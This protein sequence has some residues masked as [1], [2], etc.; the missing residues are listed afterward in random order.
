MIL[1][2]LVFLLILSV[3][4]LIHELGHFLVAKK[5]NIKVEEFG[6]GLP[7]RLFGIK[8]GETIYSLN[9]LPIGGFVKLY[10]EDE[11]GG[12]SVKIRKPKSE[13]RNA[14]IERAFFARSV[15][16]RAAVVVAGV[17]MNTLLAILIFYI[18][19]AVAGFQAQ[20]PL[21]KEHTFY[22]ANQTIKTDILISRVQKDSPADKINIPQYAQITALNTVVPVTMEEF[23]SLIKKSQGK[24]LSIT[25]IDPKTHKT[26]TKSVT[27]RVNP[28]KGQGALGVSLFGASTVT[29]RYETPVQKAFS[30]IG[31]PINLL[32]YN[33][34]LIGSLIKSSI[35]EHDATALSQGVA[36]PVGIYSLVGTIVQIPNIKERVLELLN[37]AGILSVS[38]AFFNVLPIPALD[39]GRLFFILIEGVTRKKINPK[40]EVLAHSIGMAVLLLLIVLIT[41]KDIFQFFL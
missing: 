26:V 21:L 25:W 2:A 34:D 8:R 30:G 11:A 9:W 4:V 5:L 33:F 14:D 40:Y 12:G 36:G 6:F 17:V 38:L 29:L 41:F 27:P 1:T 15:G 18:Y 19:M 28:P 35:R 16:Q 22:F 37:L 20:L 3:L 23:T 39:G 7:P 10:G 31:H 32:L 24:P 13:N